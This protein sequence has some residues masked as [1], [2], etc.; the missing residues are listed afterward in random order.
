MSRKQRNLSRSC[1]KP[2][3]IPNNDQNKRSITKEHTSNI[4]FSLYK[5][6]DM[7]IEAPITLNYTAERD[8]TSHQ[9]AQTK[10]HQLG[11]DLYPVSSLQQMDIKWM[12]LRVRFAFFK[13]YFSI[14][15]KR[16]RQL[17]R[18]KIWVIFGNKEH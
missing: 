6:W 10:I 14:D 15:D 4:F 3:C 7:D 12:R 17:L 18:L 11:T 9:Y 8:F 2:D 13:N 1:E 5:F 16:T